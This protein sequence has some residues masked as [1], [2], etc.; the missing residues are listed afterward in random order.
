MPSSPDK[1][2]AK[3]VPKFEGS[4]VPKAGVERKAPP[5]GCGRCRAHAAGHTG[6]YSPADFVELFGVANEPGTVEVPVELAELGT[7]VDVALAR[8][9][10]AKKAWGDAV[11]A[12]EAAR[13]AGGVVMRYGVAVPVVGDPE[14]IREA[15]EEERAARELLDDVGDAL[16]RARVAYQDVNGRL[17]T[18][19]ARQDYLAGQV[20]QEAERAAR[21]QA[22]QDPGWLGRLARLR[23]KVAG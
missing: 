3:P 8:Y 6:P 15:Q 2:A 5:C 17:S 18:Q 4:P 12:L 23:A 21:R 14:A 9:D 11:E 19:R 10:R 22:P 16:A 20:T 7:E 13:Q 1:P